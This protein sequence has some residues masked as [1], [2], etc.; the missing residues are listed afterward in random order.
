[1]AG[2]MILYL[3]DIPPEE[4]TVCIESLKNHHILTDIWYYIVSKQRKKCV[5]QI[6]VLQGQVAKSY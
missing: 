1:M 3:T 6:I 5:G 4:R 2:S